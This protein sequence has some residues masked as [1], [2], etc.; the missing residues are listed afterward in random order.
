L[1]KIELK[2]TIL[3]PGPEY[4]LPQNLMTNLAGM[5]SFN[6]GEWMGL[7]HHSKIS[8]ELESITSPIKNSFSELGIPMQKPFLMENF[9]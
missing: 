6:A 9:L 8:S 1:L 4:S 5:P 7:K 3:L 2:T